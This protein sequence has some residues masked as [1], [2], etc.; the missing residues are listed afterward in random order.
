MEPYQAQW[1]LL[2]AIGHIVNEQ[3]SSTLDYRTLA[4]IM[5][6]EDIMQNACFELERE[7]ERVNLAGGL[8]RSPRW[9]AY[10]Y[11]AMYAVSEPSKL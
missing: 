5:C 2:R 10:R 7:A 6:A 9:F 1:K 4:N 11:A 8:V 3:Y